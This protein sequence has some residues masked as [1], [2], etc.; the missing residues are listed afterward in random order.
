MIIKGKKIE[1]ERER[2]R[3]REREDDE[4]SHPPIEAKM[5]QCLHN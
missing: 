1:D 4:P 2:E 5:G 3:E